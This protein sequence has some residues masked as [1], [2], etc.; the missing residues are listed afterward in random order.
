ML[1]H[2]S[3]TTAYVDCPSI[4]LQAYKTQLSKL[5]KGDL[6]VQHKAEE[7]RCVAAASIIAKVYRDQTLAYLKLEVAAGRVQLVLPLRADVLA[8]MAKNSSR[9]SWVLYRSTEFTLPVETPRILR[10]LTLKIEGSHTGSR[11][12]ICLTGKT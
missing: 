3:F 6:V 9:F 10:F 7:H 1:S 11:R 4:N 12:C 5:V 2:F 8:W